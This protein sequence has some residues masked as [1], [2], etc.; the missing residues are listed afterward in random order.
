MK[1]KKELIG[2]LM[3]ALGAV[4]LILQFI[5]IDGT[6]EKK[7]SGFTNFLL[8]GSYKSVE[9]FSFSAF[10]GF[11]WLSL[12]GAL[13]VTFGAR[14][15]MSEKMELWRYFVYFGLSLC[16]LQ[17]MCM[18]LTDCNSMFS[19]SE[20]TTKTIKILQYFWPVFVGLPSI[21]VGWFVRKS[22]RKKI[23]KLYGEI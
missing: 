19:L 7:I 1:I 2:K 4:L 8:L 5:G 22:Y 15:A 23:A 11:I 14:F 21:I 17:F 9:F 3:L 16:A 10:I 18:L 6:F 12:P 13:L 20:S